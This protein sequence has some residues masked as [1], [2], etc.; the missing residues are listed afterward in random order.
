MKRAAALPMHIAEPSSLLPRARAEALRLG[1]RNLRQ[2]AIAIP[3]GGMAH[4]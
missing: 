3:S 1:G 4:A 2:A